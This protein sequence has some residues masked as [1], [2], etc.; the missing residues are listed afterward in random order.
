LTSAEQ[1]VVGLYGL[2]KILIDLGS[3]VDECNLKIWRSQQNAMASI[4]LE[5]KGFEPEALIR[6]RLEEAI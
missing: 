5:R 2:E 1:K 3:L 6:Q 4:L